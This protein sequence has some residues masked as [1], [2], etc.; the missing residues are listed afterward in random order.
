MLGLSECSLQK[1]LENGWS[2]K[3]AN[4]SASVTDLMW[5]LSE[6]FIKRPDIRVL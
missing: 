2:G 1:K 3:M 4:S 6:I 5:D